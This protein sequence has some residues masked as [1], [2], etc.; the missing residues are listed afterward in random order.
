[1]KSKHTI[2]SI[3]VGLL[4]LGTAQCSSIPYEDDIRF[5]NSAQANS[6]EWLLRVDG[7]VCKD[8]EGIIGA[9]TKRV[10][11]QSDVLLQHDPRPYG[12]R[13]DVECTDGTGIVFRHDVPKGEPWQYTL[14]H[15]DFE[16]FRSL[17]C[18]GEIFPHGRGNSLSALWQIR[19]IVFDDRYEGR[20]EIYY[21]DEEL[22]MGKHA[23]F[24][25]WCFEGKCRV[26]DEL[27][28]V[29]TEPG[30][31]AYSESEVMRFNYWN[32]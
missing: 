10:G 5:L 24:T 29:N 20:E 14:E 13:V 25:N 2:L 17:S 26:D 18:Q 15:G 6:M 32:Y 30:A 19:L 22:I 4:S 9:C 31:K 28:T 16:G 27:T 12:Y 11:S 8:M 1:M 3:T 23:K 21:L 7:A